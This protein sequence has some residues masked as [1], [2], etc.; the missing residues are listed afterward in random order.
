MHIH[1]LHPDILSDIET[2]PTVTI[3]GTNLEHDIHLSIA[4]CFGQFDEV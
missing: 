3:H 2:A 4:P 1:D